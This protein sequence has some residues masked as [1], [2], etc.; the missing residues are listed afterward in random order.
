MGM[1]FGGVF[2][3][4]VLICLYVFNVF[5]KDDPSLTG[6]LKKEEGREITG[7]WRGREREGEGERERERENLQSH[8]C[9]I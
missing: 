4:L 8:S 3:R 7:S 6:V 2:G 1:Y 9:S 5:T